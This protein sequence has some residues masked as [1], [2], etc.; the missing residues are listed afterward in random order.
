MERLAVTT[1]GQRPDLTGVLRLLHRNAKFILACSVVVTLGVGVINF[2]L[3]NRYVSSGTLLPTGGTNPAQ[4]LGN[5]AS[6]IPALEMMDTDSDP[7]SSSKLFPEMLRSDVIRKRVLAAPIPP[8][9][10]GELEASTIGEVIDNDP[11][12][13]LEELTAKTSVGKDK[14]TG[15]VTVGFE[16]TNPRFAQ[17]VASE[18]LRQLDEFCS[19]ERFA[20]LDENREFVSSRLKETEQRLHE[21]EDSLLSFREQNRNYLIGSA[22]DLQLEHE[23]L[24]RKAVEIGQVYALLAQQLEMATIEAQRK[25]PVVAALDFPSIPDKKSGPH[26]LLNI[27]QSFIAGLILASSWVLGRDYFAR[28]ITPQESADLREMRT[29]LRN[30][31]GDVTRRLRLRRKAEV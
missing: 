13:A 20:R 14:I 26:R 19:S 21:V 22:P 11:I 5:L 27:I 7:T 17:L 18:Y 31:L 23:R 28:I 25:K 24:T 9:L 12:A 29:E 4:A 15:I 3:P 16:W 2:L 10:V 30:Q 6:A 1:P 8:G